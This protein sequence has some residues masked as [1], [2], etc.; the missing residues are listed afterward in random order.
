MSVRVPRGGEN[1]HFLGTLKS[2]EQ[3]A[4]GNTTVML[5]KAKFPERGA[6][7]LCDNDLYALVFPRPWTNSRQSMLRLL[8]VD[9]AHVTNTSEFLP[10]AFTQLAEE[11]KIP[12]AFSLVVASSTE[13]VF[14][15]EENIEKG[16]V[17]RRWDMD[18]TP[19]CILYSDHLDKLIVL[20]SAFHIDRPAQRHRARQPTSKRI[21]RTFLTFL[22]LDQRSLEQEDR[23]DE[24]KGDQAS[25]LGTG[26]FRQIL[27][28]RIGEKILGMVEWYPIID[29]SKFHLLLFHTRIK[30]RKRPATGRLLFYAVARSGLND[31]EVTLK[32]TVDFASPVFSVTP[33]PD[34]SSIVYCN[35]TD[36]SVMKLDPS[37]SAIK[38]GVP[39]KTSMRSPAMRLSVVGDF[40]YVSTA[41]ESLQ[42]YQYVNN[43][44]RHWD[45]D[46][47]ARNGIN[48]TLHLGSNL[49]LA[50]DKNGN[51]TG[52]WQPT[53]EH[54]NNT[55][56]TVFDATMPRATTRFIPLNQPTYKQDVLI[57][58]R[59]I[60]LGGNDTNI[61]SRVQSARE[62]S[63]GHHLP[64]YR[65]NVLLG[66]STDGAIVQLQVMKDGWRLLKQI[67]TMCEQD[68]DICPLGP[69]RQR[70]HVGPYSDNPRFLHINGDI[71]KR[72][73][74]GDAV[75]TLQRILG[76]Q[77]PVANIDKGWT[78]DA[79]LSSEAQML[80]ELS[81][82]TFGV[83]FVDSRS[84]H[85]LLCEIVR[86]VF[87]VMRT[88]VI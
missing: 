13:L 35:G 22:D 16:L 2:V 43:Q 45:G 59:G 24:M 34:G 19:A 18:G 60:F 21:R 55:A 51:L 56:V 82:E 30:D 54:A 38:F 77:N 25:T 5:K 15:R 80:I 48:H 12:Q 1:S 49:I 33:H 61:S 10:L 41:S 11:S 42:V 64:D 84:R 63:T 27:Y 26:N 79:R 65:S 3:I 39:C 7:I 75:C 87:Y 14:A 46:A 23:E 36:L 32:K 73:L 6:L 8:S 62:G 50:S 66:L 9:N 71:L 70:S 44:L 85:D 37:P 47:I 72:L 4:V 86:W 68:P 20:S 53:K 81:R 52:L 31:V 28:C 88:I 29:G 78:C 57:P 17:S 69:K 76:I 58:G 67:Q 83:D 74:S 40:I